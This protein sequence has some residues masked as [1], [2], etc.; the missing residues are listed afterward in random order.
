VVVFRRI[1][2]S[3]KRAVVSFRW[4][5]WS[6][7]EPQDLGF[8]ESPFERQTLG[9]WGYR[10]NSH[11]HH[12]FVYYHHRE[13]EYVARKVSVQQLLIIIQGDVTISKT[14]SSRVTIKRGPGLFL[15]LTS[16][17]HNVST[18]K[19]NR[20]CKGQPYWLWRYG[21]QCLLRCYRERRRT[22]QSRQ[23]IPSSRPAH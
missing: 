22:V 12:R 14:V 8:S 15:L 1:A 3:C 7:P 16:T 19:E 10:P 20:R 6:S 21:D 2:C 18:S 17:R 23:Q 11:L 5:S 9:I 13:N 4:E